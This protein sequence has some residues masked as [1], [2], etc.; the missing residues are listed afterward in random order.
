M[1]LPNPHI[2]RSSVIALHVGALAARWRSMA[3]GS[4]LCHVRRLGR[5]GKLA[6][7]PRTPQRSLGTEAVVDSGP[8]EDMALV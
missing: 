6:R 7:Q 5:E 2:T 8:K 4:R 3:D 1:H